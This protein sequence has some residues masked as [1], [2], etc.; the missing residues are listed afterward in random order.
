MCVAESE[1]IKHNMEPALVCAV[2]DVVSEWHPEVCNATGQLIHS[3]TYSSPAEANLQSTLLGLMQ[4]SGQ[5]ARQAGY[6]QDLESLLIPELNLEIG[7]K[8][9][10]AAL[11]SC[12]GNLE[13]AL[14]V[15]YGY[16]VA[17]LIP[18][19]AAKIPA[20]KEFLSSPARPQR[21]SEVLPTT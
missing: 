3:L 14:I 10:K 4:F 5:Q 13:R 21:S 16:G 18:K 12:G 9:L 1:A 6:K 15:C 17:A 19:I 8:L 2:A 20:Y 11:A 7:I